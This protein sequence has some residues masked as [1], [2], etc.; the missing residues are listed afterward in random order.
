MQVLPRQADSRRNE[1]S[2]QSQRI[3]ELRPVEAQDDLVTHD[4]DRNLLH[5]IGGLFEILH[6]F[7]VFGDVAMGEGHALRREEFPH[8]LAAAS[9]RRREDHDVLV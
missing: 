1:S 9:G 7:R 3:L 8:G 6:G 4:D 2:I 5:T